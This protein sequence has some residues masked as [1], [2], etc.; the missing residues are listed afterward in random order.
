MPNGCTNVSRRKRLAPGRETGKVP[1]A[2]IN[3]ADVSRPEEQF[4]PLVGTGD[5]VLALLPLLLAK[6]LDLPETRIASDG[7]VSTD[8]KRCC[9]IFVSQHPQEPL[10][11][12]LRFK[13]KNY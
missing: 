4:P 11:F 8:G 2:K 10:A 5:A 9:R 6:P 7:L 3:F 13:N 12:I 1:H